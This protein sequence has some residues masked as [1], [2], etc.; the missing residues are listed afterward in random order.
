V[1]CRWSP[2]CKLGLIGVRTYLL[3]TVIFLLSAFSLNIFDVLLNVCFKLLPYK[4][5]FVLRHNDKA[6]ASEDF[7]VL[8][9]ALFF[10]LIKELHDLLAHLIEKLVLLG[11]YHHHLG[12]AC[13]KLEL[14]SDF[15][16]LEFSISVLLQLAISM[17]VQQGH[18]LLLF[19]L[20]VEDVLRRDPGDINHAVMLKGFLSSSRPLIPED[21]EIFVEQGLVDAKRFGKGE[22]A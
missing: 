5:V 22:V 17:K 14:L 21:L 1:F 13:Q 11:E 15:W 9:T 3:I 20:E 16:K 7:E 6:H 12:V 8:H 19:L 2:C 18:Q 4:F 10:V